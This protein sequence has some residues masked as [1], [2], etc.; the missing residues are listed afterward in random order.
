MSRKSVGTFSEDASFSS[1]SA[2]LGFGTTVSSVSLAADLFDFLT[3]EGEC[4]DGFLD[5]PYLVGLDVI[6][7][8]SAE[9]SLTD[10]SNI[11]LFANLFRIP[12]MSGQG[13]V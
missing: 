11:R 4:W 7:L 8:S 3:K 1:W 13:M 5:G 2:F 9:A 6:S 10:A 12:T